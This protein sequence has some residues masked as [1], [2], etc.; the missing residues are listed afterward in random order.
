MTLSQLYHRISEPFFN[1]LTRP[2]KYLSERLHALNL[3]SIA[4]YVI[5]AD[6]LAIPNSIQDEV[7][8]RLPAGLAGGN[9]PT[10][11]GGLKD[12]LLGC[13]IEILHEYA[14]IMRSHY[15]MYSYS[16]CKP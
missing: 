6:I 3:D 11:S 9:K 16:V 7:Q 14:I 1:I 2:T 15:S 13:G 8:G 4:R 5:Q 12:C 10:N